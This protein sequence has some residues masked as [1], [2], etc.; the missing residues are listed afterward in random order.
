MF[1]P[2]PISTSVR[3]NAKLPKHEVFDISLKHRYL[4]RVLKQNEGFY[5][6]LIF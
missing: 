5:C 4:L 6:S 3:K 2:F 1:S